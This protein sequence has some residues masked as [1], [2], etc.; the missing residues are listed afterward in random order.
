MRIGELARLTGTSA[1]TIR[2]YEKQ[3]LLPEPARTAANYRSYG[4][5]HRQRLTFIRR[6]RDLGFRLDAVRDLLALSDDRSQSCAAVDEIAGV[7]LREI[8]GKIAD[9]QNMQ[10]E[11]QR[12]V[13]SCQRGTVDACLIIETLNPTRPG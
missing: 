12:M 10:R 13:G 11:L 1:E 6:A 5:E 4:A 3:G 8:D 9:L 7:H 2:F